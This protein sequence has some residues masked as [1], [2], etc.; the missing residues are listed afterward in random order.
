MGRRAGLV[1]AAVLALLVTACRDTPASS[2]CEPSDQVVCVCPEGTQGTQTCRDDG[3]GFEPCRCQRVV[4]DAGGLA[5]DVQPPEDT[6]T[7]TAVPDDV[8]PED[9]ALDLAEPE[10]VSPEDADTADAAPEDAP[11]EDVEAED[12]SPEEVTPDDVAPE[13][14]APEDVA[15]EDVAVEDV[16]PP[17][18]ALGEGC[19]R[20][21]DC[22]SGTCLGFE[23]LG[24][25]TRVCSQTCCHE[26]F[27][28]PSGF[29]CL[30]LGGGTYCLPANVFPPGTTYGGAVGAPCTAGTQCQ[31][32][33][34]DTSRG[35]LGSCCTDG[36][37]TTTCRFLPAGARYR[38]YCDSLGLIA[39]GDGAPCA[40]E[41]DC[42][43]GIC[44]PDAASPFGGFCTSLCC[45][46][47]ACGGGRICGLIAGPTGGVA[48]AC[49]PATAGTGFDGGACLADADCLSDQC[50]SGACRSVCCR[51]GDC[52]PNEICAPR[53]TGFGIT[54]TFCVPRPDAP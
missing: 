23:V 7:D 21:T 39:G 25:E 34:C 6:G 29:G 19:V 31:S 18:R 8:Q 50:V 2:V 30:Q 22:A 52:L 4:A 27:D 9:V 16:A 45:S 11:P 1:T 49:V 20:D 15:P 41:F 5:P 36:D 46:S 12:V 17:V 24:V 37:C 42:A 13:D 3:T 51:D 38:T 28:C 14:V 10:D 44:L 32:G 40:G 35:C 48:R 54:T 26:G 47:S 53:E 43:S 33:L